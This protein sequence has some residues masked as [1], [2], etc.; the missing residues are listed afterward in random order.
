MGRMPVPDIRRHVFLSR[1]LVPV[2]ALALCL[3]AAP[4][5]AA[6]S[7]HSYAIRGMGAKSCHSYNQARKQQADSHYR[8]YLAGYLSAFN[9]LS[10]DTYSIG[11]G[12]STPEIMLWLDEFCGEQA[13]HSYEHALHIFTEAH[14]EQ[15]QRK[16][17]SKSGQG[18]WG[19]PP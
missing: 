11:G 13:L 18:G 8:D 7:S 12:R 2:A 17:R 5:D 1:R 16:A 6:D 4:A 19:A 14:W 15:R 9:L 3:G 10:E